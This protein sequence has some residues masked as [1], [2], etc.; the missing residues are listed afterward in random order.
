[1]KILHSF[2]SALAER[3]AVL[4]TRSVGFQRRTIHVEGISYSWHEYVLFNPVQRISLSDRVQRPLERHQHAA[5]LADREFRWQPRLVT[6][7]GETY[8]HFQTA[9]AGTKYVLGEFPWQVRVGEI[10]RSVGL[11]LSATRH[12]P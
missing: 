8:K 7:L 11:H 6:Y 12:F 2:R 1:M 9:E 5:V 4:P 10:R 3:F